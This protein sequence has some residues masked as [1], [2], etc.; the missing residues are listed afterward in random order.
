M[1]YIAIYVGTDGK[2]MCNEQT[3][4]VVNISLGDMNS[5]ELA[6]QEACSLLD[7]YPLQNGLIW[8]KSGIGGFLIHDAQEVIQI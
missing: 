4:E 6:M 2:I 8:K 1:N 7:C 5:P 3:R